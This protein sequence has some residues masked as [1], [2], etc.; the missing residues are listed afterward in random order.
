MRSI[1][2]VRAAPILFLKRRVL[3]LEIPMSLRVS[4]SLVP[5]FWTSKRKI[6]SVGAVNIVE[7]N[8]RKCPWGAA[9]DAA[10]RPRPD[11]IIISRIDLYKPS[12]YQDTAQTLHSLVN[13]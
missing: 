6:L 3:E 2:R 7:N 12:P 10:A 8:M 1:A 13:R 5:F 9:P 4:F 11:I